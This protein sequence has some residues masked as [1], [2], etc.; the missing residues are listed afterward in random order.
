MFTA[1]IRGMLAHKLRLI[2][3]TTSI[4]LGIS[5]LAGTLI[6]TDSMKVAFDQLFGKI[7]AGTDA[8]VRQEAAYTSD[9]GTSHRPTPASVLATV[10][11]VPG[12]RAADGDISGYALLTDTH[13]KAIL[14]SLSG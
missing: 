10:R 12:V 6:L 13:G 3:T 1:T 14:P 9:Q 11:S 8:V 7:S 5:F 2:L 4:M